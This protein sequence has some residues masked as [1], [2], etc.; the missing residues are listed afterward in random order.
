MATNV[1][2]FLA[3]VLA[4]GTEVTQGQTLG[5]IVGQPLCKHHSPLSSVPH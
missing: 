3:R 2:D 4:D 5:P 1:N